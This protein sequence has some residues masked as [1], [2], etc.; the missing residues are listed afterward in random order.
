MRGMAVRRRLGVSIFVDNISKRI[1]QRSLW[2]AFQE[3][4]SVLDVFIAYNST[5]RRGKA[6]TFA[7]ERFGN[8]EEA[9]SALVKAKGRWMDG[10][11]IKVFFAKKEQPKRVEDDDLVRRPQKC[12]WR[13]KDTRTFKEVLMG[14]DSPVLSKNET[15]SIRN[16]LVDS[17]IKPKGTLVRVEVVDRLRKTIVVP[18]SDMEWSRYCLV[19]CIK[20]MFNVDIIQEAL[21]SDGF[22]TTVCTWYGQMAILRFPNNEERMRCW[23]IRSELLRIWFQELELLEGFEGIKKVKTWVILYDVP[24][25]V[26]STRFFLDLANRW[27]SVIEVDDDTKNLRRFDEARVLIHTKRT[28]IIPDMM[29][30][31]VNGMVCQ[32]KVNTE[33]FEDAQR[34]IDDA[35]PTN[36]QIVEGSVDSVSDPGSDL[37]SN[38]DSIPDGQK[39]FDVTVLSVGSADLWVTSGLG[40]KTG[41]EIIEPVNYSESISHNSRLQEV[42]VEVLEEGSISEDGAQ[43][44]VGGRG[45]GGIK[46]GGFVKIRIGGPL[47]LRAGLEKFNWWVARSRKNSKSKDVTGGSSF[48]KEWKQVPVF[49]PEEEPHTQVHELGQGSPVGHTSSMEALKTLEMGNLMGVQFED[50]DEKVVARLSELEVEGL[51]R[52]KKVRAVAKVLRKSYARVAFIQESKLGVLKPNISRRLLGRNFGEME[53]SASSGASSGLISLWDT[54]FFV[55]ERKVVLDRT[56]ILVGQ[57]KPFDLKCVLIN[58]YAPNDPSERKAFFDCLSNHIVAFQLPVVMGGDFNTVKTMDDRMGASTHTGSLKCFEE[59]IQRNALIDLPLNGSEFTW[60]RG[61]IR[62]SASRLDRFLVSPEVLGC[63]NNAIQ[64][65][66][67]GGLSDHRPI[68]LKEMKVNDGLKPFKWFSHWMEEPDLVKCV[69]TTALNSGGKDVGATLREIKGAVKGWVKEFRNAQSGSYEE[70]EMKLTELENRVIVDGWDPVLGSEIRSLKIELWSILRREE[71]EWLQKSRLKWFQERDKNTKFFQLSATVRRNINRIEA[72]T[73][74]NN[75]LKDP[76]HIMGAFEDHFR[77]NYNSSSTLPIKSLEVEW[78]K[79]DFLSRS[80]LEEPFTTSEVWRAIQSADGNNAPGPDGFNLDFFKKLWPSLMHKVMEFFDEVSNGRLK[81]KGI[82]HSFVTLI[83]KIPNPRKIDDFRPISL[84]VGETQFAF[85]AGKQLSDCVLVANEVIDEVRQSRGEALS[86]LI[87]KAVELSLTEGVPMGSNGLIIS[88]LQFADDLIIFAKASVETVINIKSLLR[89]FEVIAGLRLNLVKT[90]LYGVNVEEQVIR[91]WADVIKCSSGNL[92]SE[93]LGLP[94]GQN[95]LDIWYPI[96]EKVRAK[97]EGWKCKLLSFA[98]CITHLLDALGVQL[99]FV[100]RESNVAA[101]VL[102]KQGSS[103]FWSDG[104]EELNDGGYARHGQRLADGR[105]SNGNWVREETAEGRG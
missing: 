54:K 7:F 41:L 87:K 97:L 95:C 55:L 92:P 30:F 49:T 20:P 93:Y 2:E 17:S 34:F 9:K 104:D 76:D 3:Y 81:D 21:V 70:L 39:L 69:E 50:S 46:S 72:I 12:L 35:F 40:V 33:M 65:S 43:K 60:F 84:V 67:S 28:S 5:R 44:S 105:R 85:L 62:T 80:A 79:L 8:E 11:R 73:V 14:K 102:A 63:L 101:H 78:S 27:G 32:I 89:I 36:Q 1:H 66:L 86:G 18:E 25:S 53:V 19:G 26:W 75:T 42:H 74:G 58:V 57:M 23:S 47:S 64:C 98:G 48:N 103:G 94:L 29:A 4:G 77:R 91:G 16:D 51:G 15:V 83:P 59:F 90:K 38:V 31:V 22:Q 37:G 71:R 100:H 56:I 88:H 13:L 52:L 99:S 6:T 61:G 24:L 68:V 10:F 82:N 96:I 45:N